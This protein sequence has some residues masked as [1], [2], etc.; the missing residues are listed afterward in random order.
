MVKTSRTY[1][2]PQCGARRSIPSPSAASMFA[3]CGTTFAVG[4]GAAPDVTAMQIPLQAPRQLLDRYRNAVIA[5]VLALV[6]A[7][8]LLPLLVDL[9]KQP[10][11]GCG[12]EPGQSRYV[13]PA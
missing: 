6:A 4:A 8:F 2:C 11:R 10:H 5:V 13:S 7:M 3:S 12:A 9:K 1:F